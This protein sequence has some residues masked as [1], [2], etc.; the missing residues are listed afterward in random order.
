MRTTLAVTGFLVALALP[1]V[2]CADGEKTPVPDAHATSGRDGVA[3][4]HQEAP[5]KGARSLDVGVLGGIG[6]PRPLAGLVF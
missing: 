3:A 6:F 4:H 2:A 1:R 5:S